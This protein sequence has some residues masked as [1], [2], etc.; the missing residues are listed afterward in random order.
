MTDHTLIRD[1]LAGNQ[2]AYTSLYQQEQNKVTRTLRGLSGLWDVDDLVQD[3]F[4]MAFRRL[5][6]FKG[7]AKFST[8]LHRI[9]CN[10]FLMS[11]RKRRLQLVELDDI[12]IGVLGKE[13]NHRDVFM[14]GYLRDAVTDLSPKV[15]KCFVEHTIQG[16]SCIEVAK[17]NNCAVGTVKGYNNRAKGIIRTALKADLIPLKKQLH[18]GNQI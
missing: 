7:E 9:A 11:V 8:W 17:M 6:T 13:D 12:L 10:M 5:S 2:E 4:I 1:A 16:F 15:R 14:E 3:T 18:T